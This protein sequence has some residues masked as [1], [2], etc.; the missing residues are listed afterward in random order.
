VPLAEPRRAR[1]HGCIMGL[2]HPPCC[3]TRAAARRPPT[4]LPAFAALSMLAA[5]TAAGCGRE[6]APQRVLVGATT[7]VQDTGL[8]DELARA[9]AASQPRWRLVVVAVG[10]G[11][12]LRMAER[13]DFDVVLA[14]APADETAF[15]AAGHGE[16]RITFMGNDFVLVGPAADPAGAMLLPLAAALRRIA[17][18][19]YP[20][21]SR[22]DR[23]GT[24]QAELALLAGAGVQPG[25]GAYI[26]AGAGMADALRVASARGAYAL[27]DRA[28]FEV[29]RDQL[30]L[31][32]VQEGDTSLE[33]PYSIIV[34][35]R[36]RNS[37]G[38]RAFA[39]WLAGPAGQRLIAGFGVE[40]LGRPIFEP[41]V[42][43]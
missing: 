15:M 28:T 2:P 42:A 34:A 17:A 25:W 8:A 12:A 33:N 32:I 35:N 20:F 9:F 13:G 3:L 19:G 37:V 7:S 23:S 24:H 11:E 21:V 39:G 6:A 31:R 18:E 16:S 43:P 22:G 29:L 36:A 27:T 14:H 5:A 1:Y 40:R 10:S 26:E 4:R 30:Q 38:A 41:A